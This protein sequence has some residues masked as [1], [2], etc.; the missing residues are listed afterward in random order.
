MFADSS[1]STRK[2]KIDQVTSEF[3]SKLSKE[4]F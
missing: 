4:E 1:F 2:E 3:L